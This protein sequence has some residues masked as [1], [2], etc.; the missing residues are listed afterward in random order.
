MER[1]LVGALVLVLAVVA[2][3]AGNGRTKELAGTPERGPVPGPPKV[4][5]CVVERLEDR[6]FAVDTGG[7]GGDFSGISDGSEG[8]SYLSTPTAVTRSCSDRRYGE[9]VAVIADGMDYLPPEQFTDEP[10]PDDPWMRCDAAV[11][12][13]LDAAPIDDREWVPSASPSGALFGPS[14]LQLAL[15]QRWLGCAVMAY[16]ASGEETYV[17]SLAGSMRTLTIPPDFAVCLE[18]VP[19][20][21]GIGGEVTA[22]DNPHQAEQFGAVYRDREVAA[23]GRQL[24]AS[25]PDLAS[26]L[27]RM[28]DPTAG[29][30][31]H[32]EVNEMRMLAYDEAG[33]PLTDASA[34]TYACLLVANRDAK[35]TGPLLGLAEAPL[36]IR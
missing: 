29:G 20:P 11:Q 10:D 5:E 28:P 15:G 18:T 1:R 30:R 8:G 26:A 25:C 16:T 6:T 27:T 19:Q 12:G 17:G 14:A 22:C 35:L 31:L 23:D 7:T 24:A 2:A 34:I 13:F 36:P 3:L 4:G 32:I 33:D 9:V 21:N